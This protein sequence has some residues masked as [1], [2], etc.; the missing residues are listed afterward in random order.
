MSTI[1]PVV[2]AVG[3]P[4]HNLSDESM[5]YS[6]NML[7]V[8]LLAMYS[9]IRL[10]RL[11]SLLR[12]P[13]EWKNG[14]I[15]H[16]TPYRPK[17]RLVQAIHSAY[18]PPKDHQTDESHTFYS[19]AHLVQRLTEKGTPITLDPPP[20]IPACIKPLRP[21]LT[22]FRVRI[23]P[24]FSVA[25]LLVIS[26]YFY[27]LLYAALYKSNIFTASTRTA[28]ICIGQMPFVFIFAQKNNVLGSILGYG[29]EKV[30]LY[31]NISLLRTLQSLFP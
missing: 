2:D 19:D 11:F 9:I 25:Q 5:V 10:P 20:H 28:W 1:S 23:A 15:L 30:S 8:A 17:R 12:I 21:L 4:A 27:S 24:G 22:P 13:S 14:H 29:Y 18:P 31:P 3:L 6:I 26:T 16:Y 7:L